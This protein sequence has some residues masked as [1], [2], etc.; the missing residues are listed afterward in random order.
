VTLIREN[1]PTPVDYFEARGQKVTGKRGKH[2]RTA[3]AIHGGDGDTLSV[4]REDG[5]F[6]CFSCGAKGGDIVAYAMQADGL[7]FVAAC[8]SLG[9]WVD[10]GKP[11]VHHKPTALTARQALHLLSFE[12]RLVAIEVARACHGI[13]PD[14]QTKDRLLQAAGRINM[15]REEFP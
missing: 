2:F 7:D 11:E 5:G 9:A 1:L 13:F 10:D 6:N 4:L 15:V 3:C 12:A 8:K 14:E